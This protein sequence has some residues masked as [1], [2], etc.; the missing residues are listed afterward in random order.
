M[1]DDGSLRGLK[2][3]IIGCGGAGCKWVNAAYLKGIEEIDTIAVDTD[4]DNL[5][6]IAARYRIL[7][8]KT[9]TAG[10]GAGGYLDIGE[11]AAETARTT[12]EQY[13][14]GADIVF[15]CAGLGGGTGTG[16]APIIAQIA[17]S[18][19]ALVI[20]IVSLPFRVERARISK[21]KEGLERML[22]WTDTLIVLD[23]ERMFRKEYPPP[24][25]LDGFFHWTVAFL[26][27]IIEG[28]VEP[29]KNYQFEW[30]GFHEVF[31]KGGLAVLCIGE[32][33]PSNRID[34]VIHATLMNPSF[35]IRDFKD[36]QGAYILGFGDN[37]TIADFEDIA[38]GLT[39]DLPNDAIV[40]RGWREN[41]DYRGVVRVI[42]IMTGIP[43]EN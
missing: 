37:I 28:I 13:L 31:S 14:S 40:Y 2:L 29:V 12:L 38:M 22:K 25:S 34:N 16:A 21:A 27:I 9:L 23:N 7:I 10:R 5:Q 35:E 43:Y 24:H 19:G 30:S 18:E 41:E 4:R 8:G 26:E 32:S 33:L 20:G 17:K 36:V 15:L 42:Y 1:T 6:K 3:A 11:Q 39:A